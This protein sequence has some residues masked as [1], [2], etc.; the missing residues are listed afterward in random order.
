M[1][2]K[3]KKGVK[4]GAKRPIARKA[5]AKRSQVS[6]V[7]DVPHGD[8]L[9]FTYDTPV[10]EIDSIFGRHPDKYADMKY[11]D[12]LKKIGQHTLSKIFKQITEKYE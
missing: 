8:H 2:K 11:G 10:G 9:P 7:Q 6:R 12:Y 1:K 4:R 5:T 3:A